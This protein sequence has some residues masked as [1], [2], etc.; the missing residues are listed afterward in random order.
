MLFSLLM[1]TAKA[2]FFF[3][4]QHSAIQICFSAK[5]QTTKVKLLNQGVKNSKIPLENN[6]IE[7]RDAVTLDSK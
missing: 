7:Q 5:S 2:F 4:Y 1:N 3:F 6:Y